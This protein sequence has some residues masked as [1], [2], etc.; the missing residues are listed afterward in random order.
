MSF[1]PANAIE[2][3]LHN[4]SAKAMIIIEFDD[5]RIYGHATIQ[6]A[7]GSAAYKLIEREC[8]DTALKV[9]NSN[10]NDKRDYCAAA[11]WRATF[12]LIEAGRIVGAPCI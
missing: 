9:W 5:M 4:E 7:I 11:L 1:T 3:V 6:H 12:V 8:G 2:N 10:A